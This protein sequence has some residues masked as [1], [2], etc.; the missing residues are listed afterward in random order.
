MSNLKKVPTNANTIRVN[1]RPAYP[2]TNFPDEL[3]DKATQL[4]DNKFRFV[5]VEAGGAGD[6]FSRLI[7]G[8]LDIVYSG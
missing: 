1:F 2:N 5:Q 3:L 6:A 7:K 4:S 8:E